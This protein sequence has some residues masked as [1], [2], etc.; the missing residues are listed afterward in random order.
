MKNRN[1]VNKSKT[2]Q[3]LQIRVATT[4]ANI[5]GIVRS[6]LKERGQHG[7]REK[8]KNVS[9]ETLGNL[10]KSDKGSLDNQREW[11][12]EYEYGKDMFYSE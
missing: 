4:S 10:A 1:N 6:V 5:K 11:L 2:Q 8:N 9:L 7:I 12:E 3:I